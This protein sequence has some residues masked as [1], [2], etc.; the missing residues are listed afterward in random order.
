MGECLLARHGGVT[1][2]LPVGAIVLW[3]GA[4]NAI[5]AGWH[6]CDGTDGTPD[7]RGRFVVGAG[8]SYAVGAK[9][10]AESV[11]LTVEQ[12]PTHSHSFPV[13]A[14][15]GSAGDS[16]VEASKRR[17]STTQSTD[18]AGGGAAHENRPPYYALCYIMRIK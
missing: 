17:D 14:S 3:S 7:L 4:A 13:D 16:Y 15:N 18:S 6:L 1:G 5:P 12:M 11:T 9:G 10:G 2:G 8:G